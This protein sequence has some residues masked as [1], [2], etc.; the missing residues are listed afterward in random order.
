MSDFS[1]AL[2]CVPRPVKRL[3]KVRRPITALLTLARLRAKEGRAFVAS[4]GPTVAG[5][6]AALSSAAGA[7]PKAL[8]RGPA[9]PGARAAQDVLVPGQPLGPAPDR[10]EERPRP[11]EAHL[12]PPARLPPQA[13]GDRRA[14]ARAGHD[15]LPQAGRRRG[16]RACWAGPARRPGAATSG[17]SRRSGSRSPLRA[18]AA[19]RRP[20]STSSMWARGR[21]RGRPGRVPPSRARRGRRARRAAVAAPGRRPGVARVYGDDSTAENQC[22]IF[23]D[24][25]NAGQRRRAGQPDALPQR[26]GGAVR[27][28]G[29]HPGAGRGGDDDGEA[30]SPVRAVQQR[31]RHGRCHRRGGGDRRGEQRRLRRRHAVD[32][33]RHAR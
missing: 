24:V 11:G 1:N 15:H 19:R 26:S 23:A 12:P 21:P 14:H 7:W 2:G 27:R 33:Q 3:G 18:R 4:A 25:R 5:A 17:C 29:G 30:G 31:R 6:R 8:A 16:G 22:D 10:A 13:A 28:A 9:R 32:L 20:A